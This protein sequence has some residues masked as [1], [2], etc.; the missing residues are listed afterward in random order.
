MRTR[1]IV[2]HGLSSSIILFDIISLTARSSREKHYWTWN[3]FW[4]SLQLLCEISLILRRIQGDTILNVQM[5]HIQHP[6]LLSDI[7]GTSIFSKDFQN[8]SKYQIPWRSVQ[9]ETRW[10]IRKMGGRTGRS[11][12]SLFAVFQTRLKWI[13]L[14]GLNL[15]NTWKGLLTDCHE[16][17]NEYFSLQNGKWFFWPPERIIEY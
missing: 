17:G 2:I 13:K 11:W 8:V 7:N 1:H 12:Q 10:S 14:C 16:Q 15:C 6:L 5:L 9:W 3:V 4:L